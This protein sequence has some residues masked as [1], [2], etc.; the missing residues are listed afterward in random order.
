MVG[1]VLLVS[2]QIVPGA[3]LLGMAALSA[4]AFYLW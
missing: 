3:V 4:L 2:G 1:I